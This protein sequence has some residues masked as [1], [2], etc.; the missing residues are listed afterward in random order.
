MR[1]VKDLIHSRMAD[2]KKKIV[3]VDMEWSYSI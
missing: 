1:N 3:A 2:W